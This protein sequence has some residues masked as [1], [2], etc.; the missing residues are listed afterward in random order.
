MAWMNF[1][2]CCRILCLMLKSNLV[3]CHGVV[4]NLLEAYNYYFVNIAM[5]VNVIIKI[6]YAEI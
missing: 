6:L 2:F 5:L 4:C 1:A 3:F